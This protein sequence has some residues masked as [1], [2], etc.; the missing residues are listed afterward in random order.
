MTIRH[1][2]TGYDSAINWEQW[3]VKLYGDGKLIV[4]AE[5]LKSNAHVHFHGESPHNEKD[6]AKVFKSFK[7][8]HPIKRI[9]GASK[10]RPTKEMK[11]PA[12]EMG[13]QYLAKEKHTLYTQGFT[14]EELVELR[15]ASDEHVKHLKNGM[16]DHIHGLKYAGTPA[17]VFLNILDDCGSFIVKEKVT[18]RPQLITDVYNIM[19]THPDATEAWGKW[20][21]YRR[22]GLK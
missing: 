10:L 8:D 20:T 2:V 22:A 17:E 18:T 19:T 5:H 12:D 6:W 9:P 4:A 13:Y 1:F 21:L 7:D 14:E 11:K 15:A 16:K 3:A